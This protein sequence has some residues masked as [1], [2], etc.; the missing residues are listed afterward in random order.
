MPSCVCSAL[1]GVRNEFSTTAMRLSALLHEKLEEVP[2]ADAEYR[3]NTSS[4]LSWAAAESAVATAGGVAC[5][6]TYAQDRNVV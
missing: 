3:S 1:S 4:R 5:A 6:L 2:Q